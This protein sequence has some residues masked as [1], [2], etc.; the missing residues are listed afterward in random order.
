MGFLYMVWAFGRGSLL[1]IKPWRRAQARRHPRMNRAGKTG[2]L[3]AISRVDCANPFRIFA[4]PFAFW[5]LTRCGRPQARVLAGRDCHGKGPLFLWECDWVPPPKLLPGPVARYL[6]G[7]TGAGIF[8]FLIR[9][10]VLTITPS[11]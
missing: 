9:S 11:I 2:V 1:A 6:F 4:G 3:R 8:R 10:A 7:F 5:D